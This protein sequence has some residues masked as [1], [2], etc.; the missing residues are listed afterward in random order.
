MKTSHP[1]LRVTVVVALSLFF[2]VSYFPDL[3]RV[4]GHPNGDWG[5]RTNGT[6]V[7]VVRPDSPAQRAGIRPGDRIDISA[8]PEKIRWATLGGLAIAPGDALT[9]KIWKHGRFEDVALRAIAERNVAAFIVIRELAF[10]LPLVIGVF[11]V[12]LRPSPITWGFFLFSLAAG[13]AP[14]NAVLPDRLLPWSVSTAWFRVYI[15]LFNV[16]PKTGL[17]LFAFALARRPLG[18]WRTAAISAVAALGIISTVPFYVFNDTIGWPQLTAWCDIAAYAIALLGLFDAYSHVTMRLRQRLHWITAGFIFWVAIDV[19]DAL[20]WPA[21]EPYWVHTTIDAAQVIFPLVVAYAIF[22][23][24]VVDI[25]FVI[26]RTV[27]YGILTTAIVGVFAL[28]DLFLSRTMEARFSLPVDIVV[29]LVLGFF[30]HGMRNRIDAGVDRVIF[31]KRH[32]A[33]TRLAKAAKAVVHVDDPS[34]IADYLTR[35]PVEVLD[36]TGAA[37]YLRRGNGFALERWAGWKHEPAASLPTS[38]PLVAFLSSELDC[39]RVSDV[40]M[41]EAPPDRHDVPVL[42]IPLVFRRELAGFAL[43]GVHEDGAD[44]DTDDEQAL[45]PLVNNAAVTYDHIEAQAL[46]EEIL[47]LRSLQAVPS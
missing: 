28:I 15:L 21:Y 7:T 19:V 20:L 14:P 31:R 30:F 10:L 4:V 17:A 22:R 12:L 40:P 29:A 46:R 18:A 27:A 33:E 3:L 42:A 45:V 44:L 16:V 34:A 2:C 38:D 13:G 6:I 24:R 32:I 25:N 41:R 39:V 43:Y 1:A 47:K 5:F 37:L 11:L 36:L 35:L 23:E 8:F 9:F 26:S